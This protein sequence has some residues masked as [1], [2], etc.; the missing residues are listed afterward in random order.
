M[1]AQSWLRLREIRWLSA[2]RQRSRRRHRPLVERLEDRTVPAAVSWDGG[3]G[4]L[5]WNDAANWDTNALPTATDDVVIDVPASAITVTH[6]SGTTSIHSLTCQESLTLSGG[7]FSIAAPSTIAGA[8]ALSGGSLSGAGGL[9]VSGL[10]TWTGGGMSGLGVT[11]ADGGLLINGAGT[12][13][14]SEEHTSELQ[15]LRHL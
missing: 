10:T 14:R 12:K 7:S 4:T 11:N 15:S 2:L 13:D 3:A 1:S 6:G 8:F 9:T 5:N